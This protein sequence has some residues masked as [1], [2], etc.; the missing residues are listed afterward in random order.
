[1]GSVVPIMVI[2]LGWIQAV[3][4]IMQWL[5][6]TPSLHGDYA[7]TGS[8]YNPGPY[9]CYLAVTLPVAVNSALHSN[10]KFQ[11]WLG[12][13]MVF[14]CAILIPAS[15]SRTALA[16]S[17]IGVTVTVADRIIPILRTVRKPWV[18]VS[19]A[20]I[21]IG[22]FGIYAV[23]KDSA[24]GRLLMWKVA[25]GAV[26]DVPAG[27]V[28]WDKVAGCYGEAQ[29]EYF[30]SD[31]GSERERM[32][33]DA[34]E[35][36]FN[37]YLQTAI[38]FGPMVTLWMTVII[39]CGLIV[40]LRNRRNGIGGS[41]AAVMAVMFASYPLQFPLFV[42]TIGIVLCGSYLSARSLSMRIAG[43]IAVIGSCWWF[44]NHDDTKD[45][46]TA[47][48]VGHA[49]H[50]TG[51]FSRSNDYLIELLSHSSDPMILNIIGKN[52][53]ALGMADS[54]EYYL[55]KSANRCPNRLYPHYLLMQLYGDTLSLD[56]QAQ[57]REAEIIMTM[58]EKI[59]SPAVEEMRSEAEKVLTQNTLSDISQR[60]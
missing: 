35:Y 27:G 10:N 26:A 54:A 19:A 52:Y 12:T 33:A 44:L 42:V 47:F 1:M 45:V 8:F 38:A 49:I 56:R 39:A 40:S 50:R 22:C 21:A 51:D 48:A 24:H 34:P 43:C 2:S 17:A 15:M 59:L 16:A 18:V 20:I 4:G 29:E 9:A 53:R 36:V 55:K 57:R 28:G 25:T 41:V 31:R 58:Q 6:F 30:A 7:F 60:Q 5:G 46:R 37:E 32:V 3:I 23:K 11:K 13:G 14:L